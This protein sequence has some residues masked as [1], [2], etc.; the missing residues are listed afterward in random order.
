MADCSD[1]LRELEP[2]LDGELSP[3]AQEHIN[4]HL[5]GCVDCQQAYEFH[6]EF[7]LAV[8]RKAANDEIPD[9]LIQRLEF[10]L[11]EDIDGDGTVAGGLAR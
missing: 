6:H 9:D 3:E 7:K 10:C 8:R 11:R 1:T 4:G 5:D 2:Y